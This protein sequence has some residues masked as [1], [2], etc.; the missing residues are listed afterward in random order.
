MSDKQKCAKCGK[1]SGSLYGNPKAEKPEYVCFD[2]LDEIAP[3]YVSKYP[4]WRERERTKR[5]RAEQA[6]RNFQH[7]DTEAQR[8]LSL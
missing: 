5:Q 1:E 6:R 7:R 4:G 3:D 8:G 2:C